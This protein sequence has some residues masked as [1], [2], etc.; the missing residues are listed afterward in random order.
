MHWLSCVRMY[1]V[2]SVQPSSQCPLCSRCRYDYIKQKIFTISLSVLHLHCTRTRVG[3]IDQSIRARF[4]DS[5]GVECTFRIPQHREIS[6]YKYIHR[7]CAFHPSRKSL[8]TEH[9]SWSTRSDSRNRTARVFVCVCLCRC[10]SVGCVCLG[11]SPL[12]VEWV[13]WMFRCRALLGSD[14]LC[15]CVMLC[16]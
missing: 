11:V 6:T 10:A 9:R 7:R 5:S 1:C 14:V 12:R 15:V 3:R 16:K 8:H 13:L 4:T 2:P